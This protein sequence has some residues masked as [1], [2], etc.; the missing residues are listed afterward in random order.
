MSIHK[1]HLLATEPELPAAVFRPVPV[2]ITFRHM[3]TSAAVVAH[4]EA[5]VQKLQRYFKP[6][7]H[8]HVVVVAPHQHHLR[9]HH[10]TVHVDLDVPGGPLV[11]NHEPVAK[12]ESAREEPAGKSDEIDATHKDIYVVL[13]DAFDIARRQLEDYV[14]RKHDEVKRPH[15]DIGVEAPGP[16][17]RPRTAR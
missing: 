16:N 11:V 7:M 8:C 10:Y 4:V 12:R 3:A 1:K 6:I 5:E 17:P 14:R 9:G 15:L 2:Q 13:R